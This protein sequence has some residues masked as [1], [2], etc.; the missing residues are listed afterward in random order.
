MA[1]EAN[2]RTAA[3]ALAR[4]GIAAWPRFG[5]DEASFAAHLAT[6]AG[7]SSDHAADLALAFACLSGSST[8]AAELD[9]R[10]R[11]GALASAARQCAGRL[12]ADDLRGKVLQRLLMADGGRSAKL[13][14]YAGRGPLDAWLRVVAIRVAL[15]AAP[16]PE[17]EVPLDEH[18]VAEGGPATGHPELDLLRE[19]FRDD[20]RQ[21]VRSAVGAL[22]ARD[23]TVLRLSVVD[24]LGID[25]IGRSF[26]VHRA[27]VARWIVAAREQIVAGTREALREDLRL[28]PAELESLMGLADSRLDVS[29][30][31][32][33]KENE[34]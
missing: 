26:R 27:T 10:L 2:P 9:R 14:E 7:A 12:G 30:G 31:R 25:E 15:N 18:L 22:S 11:A 33:L 32:F 24:G 8:A 21:A 19:R 34:C 3:L 4:A 1:D 23:R 16:P 6:L 29:L 5:I 17:R 13:A 20:F 28:R